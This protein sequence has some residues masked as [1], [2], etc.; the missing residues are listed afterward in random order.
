MTIRYLDGPEILLKGTQAV[1]ATSANGVRALARR[2]ANREVPIYAVGPQTAATAREAGFVQVR[3]AG[4]DA[5]NLANAVREWADQKAGPL[6]H[7]AGQKR[8]GRLA[9]SLADAG[10]SVQVQVVYAAVESEQF[11]PAALAALSD[12]AVDAAML[13]SP[14]SARVFAEHIR[15]T[16][17]QASCRKMIALCVSKAAAEPLQ[18]V[19]FRTVHVARQPD[20]DAMLALLDEPGAAS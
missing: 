8:A 9:Q 7:V 11:S 6:L 2:T 15:K 17:L 20:Q 13:F 18:G 3:N 19:P 4:G 12:N 1:L 16:E 10:F 14:R 5:A